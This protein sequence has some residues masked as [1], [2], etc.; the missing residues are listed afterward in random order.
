MLDKEKFIDHLFYDGRRDYDRIDGDV[1]YLD[2]KPLTRPAVMPKP[3]RIVLAVLVAIA[4]VVGLVI[5]RDVVVTPI[6]ASLTSEETIAAN[7]ARPASLETVP[8]V[9]ELIDLDD[10]AIQARLQSEG[11]TFYDATSLTDS[12]NMMLFKIPSDMTL[13]QAAALY[14][15]GVGSL[16]AS[17]ATRLL[18]GSWVL[19]VDRINTTSMV[20]RYADFSTADLQAAIQNALAK[21]GFDASTVTDS[22]VDD[23]GNTYTAGTLETAGGPCHWRISALPLNEMYSIRGLPE[24]ACYVGIRITKG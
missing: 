24:D 7:I 19:S 10:A 6:Q 22:G 15:R 2:G 5:L 12:G 18:C 8:P 13:D 14:L 21:E 16:S 9:A 17:D 4:V 11:L 1:A 3:Q 23:S 20:V